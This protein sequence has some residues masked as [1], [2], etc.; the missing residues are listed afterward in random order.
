LSLE[1]EFFL[2]VFGLSVKL[3]MRSSRASMST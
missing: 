2:L 1:E 3:R